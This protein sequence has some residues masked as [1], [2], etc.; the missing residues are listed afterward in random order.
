MAPGRPET[1]PR[2]LPDL[3]TWLPGLWP[4]GGRKPSRVRIRRIH[5]LK[6]ENARDCSH[7][8]FVTPP[9]SGQELFCLFFICFMRVWRA[10]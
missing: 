8:L 4:R 2:D 7:R 1:L 5:G 6:G 9:K 3:R 10:T